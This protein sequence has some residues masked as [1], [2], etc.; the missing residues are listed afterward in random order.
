M[1]QTLL[2][3]VRFMMSLADLPKSFWGY[4]LETAVYVLN[5]VPSNSV[6]ITPY[7]IWCNKKPTLSYMRV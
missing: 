6:D 1:N 4:A 5:R 2:D 3:I 7:E